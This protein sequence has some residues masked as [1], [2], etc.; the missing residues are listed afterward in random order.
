M[1]TCETPATHQIAE[2]GL[3]LCPEHA[4]QAKRGGALVEIRP[5]PEPGGKRKAEPV[6][7]QQ[8]EPEETAGEPELATELEAGEG[9]DS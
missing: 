3:P 2:G 9:A 5:A 6:I 4:S 1:T 7:C 8:V